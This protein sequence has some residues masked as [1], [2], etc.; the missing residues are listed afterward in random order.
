MTRDAEMRATDFVHLVLRN[1]GARDRP[2]GPVR[3]C[4]GS[5]RWPP[6]PTP[7]RTTASS[8]TA[9]WEAGA[10]HARRGGR[11]RQRPPADLRP[12]LRAVGPQRRGAR[13][14]ARRCSTARG[15][16]EGLAVDQDLRWTLAHR[17]GPGRPGRRRARSS[18]SSRATAPSSGQERAAAVRASPP[19]GRG[20]GR[21]LGDRD[22]RQET[23]NETSRSIVLSFM[24]PGQADVLGPY[25]EQYLEAAET[26][27]DDARHPQGVRRARAHLPAGRSASPEL[28]ERV[29]DWL[30][31]TDG[32]RRARSATSPRAGP[33]SSARWP[34]RSGTRGPERGSAAR[35][36]RALAEGRSTDVT[37]LRRAGVLGELGDAADQ[38]ADQVALGERRAH[39][40]DGELDRAG[41]RACG[42][43][44]RR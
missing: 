43:R 36:A 14:P 8:C 30:A 35:S 15:R 40:E 42:V 7:R 13:R 16:L 4:P 18:P 22:A 1:I 9:E 20:E 12:P 27:W 37:G 31:T 3:R 19:D 33:T 10:A 23:P 34:P 5:P 41:R 21:G 25:L 17:A 29:D 39:L 11:A 38:A 28:L 24:R 2:V 26:L 44:R 32:Q 6:T